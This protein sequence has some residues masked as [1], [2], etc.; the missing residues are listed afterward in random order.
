M[1][2]WGWKSFEQCVKPYY[3]T[4]LG[5]SSAFTGPKFMSKVL[6]E[7][8]INLPSH[9]CWPLKEISPSLATT[10]KTSESYAFH[11]LLFNTTYWGKTCF[12]C[13]KQ[14]VGIVGW[15]WWIKTKTFFL[16]YKQ[17]SRDQTKGRRPSLFPDKFI[18]NDK[19]LLET[20]YIHGSTLIT[21]DCIE[22][23][24]GLH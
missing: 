10:Q 3:Q 14:L 4:L 22:G 20:T 12:H 19:N 18:A 17:M 2:N 7:Q 9:S 8:I 5:F 13:W 15:R 24:L 11:S 1:R 6:S 21:S 23:D 16:T